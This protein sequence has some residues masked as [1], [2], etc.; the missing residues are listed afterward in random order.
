MKGIILAGGA[1]TW[2]Y[3]VT[4]TISKQ[5]LPIYDKPMIYFPLSVLMT[6]GIREILIISTPRDLP[7]F[8]ELFG[9]GS[10]LGLS[11]SYTE[12]PSPDGLA[13]A[14]IIGKEF[15]GSDTVCL[16]LGD[17]LFYGEGLVVIDSDYFKDNRGYFREIFHSKNFDE[18]N[19]DFVQDNFSHSN[20]N[21]LRGLSYQLQNPQGKLITVVQGEIFDVAVD[22]RKESPTFGKWFGLILSSENRKQ[23]YIPPGYAHGFC[24]LSGHADVF[25]KCTDLY[26]PGDEY[27]LL[28]SDPEININWPV[29]DPVVSE[30]DA[31]ASKLSEISPE[32]LPEYTK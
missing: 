1:G 20:K 21:V 13:Q 29:S 11:F 31:S 18:L 4:Q 7:R 30:K 3:P 22:I 8:K 14:F 23:I 19:V 2:L 15:I 25:Y 9:D 17:N 5:L 28:W 16:I 26:S 24:V 6:A 12:Q 32:L 10:Q 27:A